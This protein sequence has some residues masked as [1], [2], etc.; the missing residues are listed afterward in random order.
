MKIRTSENPHAFQTRLFN[1]LHACSLQGLL[2]NDR[3]E[4]TTAVEAVEYE[5]GDDTSIVPFPRSHCMPGMCSPVKRGC[6]FMCC[7]I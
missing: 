1:R 3:H 4:F 5:A 2:M 6:R 7:A